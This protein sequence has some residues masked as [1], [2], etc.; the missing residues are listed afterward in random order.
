MQNGLKLFSGHIL[1]TGPCQIKLLNTLRKQRKQTRKNFKV[2]GPGI[3]LFHANMIKLHFTVVDIRPQQTGAQGSDNPNLFSVC[4]LS[5]T[6]TL[7]V[8]LYLTL[9]LSNEA[10]SGM[11][12]CGET[13]SILESHF[14]LQILVYLNLMSTKR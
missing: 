1:A 14:H 8:K 5:T 7:L 9:A 10:P 6:E 2:I 3:T 13:E 4:F 11:R 12:H